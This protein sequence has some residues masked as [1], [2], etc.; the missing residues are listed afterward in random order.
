MALVKAA[1]R[2]LTQPPPP[3]PLPPWPWRLLP[4][5]ACPPQ[6][7]GS[8]PLPPQACLGQREGL[9]EQRPPPLGPWPLTPRHGPSQAL[10]HT[11]AV[12]AAAA[13]TTTV[14]MI[15]M[16]GGIRA[17][18]AGAA[19]VAGVAAQ[20]VG[21][22]WQQGGQGSHTTLAHTLNTNVYSNQSSSSS[23]RAR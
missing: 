3:L 17:R 15:W 20:Q 2:P 21:A 13:A 16:A 12:R 11:Q 23:S 6:Q 8:L 4:P 1:P 5:P 14:G 22:R 18:V 19:G 9:R 7:P 10:T